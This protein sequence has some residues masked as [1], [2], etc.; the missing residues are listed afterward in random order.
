MQR[1]TTLLVERDALI[2]MPT[3]LLME[4]DAVAIK[5]LIPLKMVQEGEPIWP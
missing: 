1:A 4:E 5:H 2:V 3:Y